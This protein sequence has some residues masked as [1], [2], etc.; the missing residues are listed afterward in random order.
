MFTIRLMHT[1]VTIGGLTL[2]SRLIGFVR[3]ILT[4]IFLGAGPISDAFFVALRFPNFFRRLFAEGA[5]HGAF[6]PLFTAEY[7]DHGKRA[8]L[9]FASDVLS[10]M[11][12]IL[13]PFSLFVIILMPYLLMVVAPGF[14]ARPAQFAL[15]VD[16]TRITFCYLICISLVALLGGMLN[17]MN[18]FAPFAAIPIVFNV[19]LIV[20]LG[21]SSWFGVLPSYALAYGISIA[22]VVQL[23]MMWYVAQRNGITLHVTYPR[24]T[25]QIRKLLRLI[26]P[27]AFGALVMQI[28]SFID[29]F[30]GSLV[31]A[32]A[33]SYLYYAERL[34]QLPLAVIGIALGTSLLPM[35]SRSIASG[36][37]VQAHFTL[38]RGLEIGFLFGLPAAIGLGIAAELIMSVLF[39]RGAFDSSAT[40]AAAYA[41]RAY[42]LGIPAYVAIKILNADYFAHQDTLSPV[43]AAIITL[44]VNVL[45]AYSLIDILGHVGI[46]LATGL[47]TWLN[48]VLLMV[49]LRP[50]G[51][52]RIDYPFVRRILYMSICAVMMGVVVYGIISVSDRWVT[53]GS[54]IDRVLVLICVLIGGGVS[55]GSLAVMFGV[56]S[57]EE[58]RDL[59]RLRDIK[60]T[61]RHKIK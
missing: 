10:V 7:H 20:A 29:I 30:L 33:I 58:L 46:A 35:L 3:D 1:L 15:A 11:L 37:D 54:S 48:V 12:M 44:I 50:R 24:I 34:Y 61:K 6:I 60:T 45:L 42:A 40:Q 41:L 39:E 38:N 31:G 47:T 23:V 17:S 32:G 36:N 26:G 4:A 27:G 5:F 16:L 8:A 9:S 19:G 55:Y 2:I 43:K 59:F 18:H 52:L 28:T 49:G 56:I 51:Y 57:M 22:G 14:E 13:V 21:I 53:V 25:P